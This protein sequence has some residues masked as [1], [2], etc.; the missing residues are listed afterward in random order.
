MEIIMSE[1]DIVIREEKDLYDALQRMLGGEDIDASLIK[2]E[3]YPKYEIIL[4]GEDF[5]GGLPTRILPSLMKF[6][7]NLRDTYS[8]L[9]YGEKGKL[10]EDDKRRT[11]LVIYTDASKST[12]FWAD[13]ADEILNKA[14]EY[15][16]QNMTGAQITIAILGIAFIWGGTQSYKMYLDYNLKVKEINKNL[17]FS[18]EETKRQEMLMKAMNRSTLVQEQALKTNEIN[19]SIAKALWNDDRLVFENGETIDKDT[20]KKATRKAREPALETRLDGSFKILSVDSGN[21]KDGFKIKVE[22]VDDGKTFVVTVPAGTL[23]E[24]KIEILQEGEWQK[25]ILDMEINANQS[26]D[27]IYKATLVKAG[28]KKR[29]N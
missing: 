22:R 11:E 29:D 25:E 17:R 20:V 13:K 23:S 6:Q 28:L 4:R 8:Q 24:K 5:S 3:G 10:D 9:K 26:G 1:H 18:E 19:N 2:F 21:V 12:R 27:R 14:L 15:G 7:Q 16:V